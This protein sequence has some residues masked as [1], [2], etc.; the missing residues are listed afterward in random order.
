[1]KRQRH[2]K[3]QIAF[4]LQQIELGAPMQEVCRNTQV[5]TKKTKANFIQFL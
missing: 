3:E 2:T 5:F 1:M 4:V